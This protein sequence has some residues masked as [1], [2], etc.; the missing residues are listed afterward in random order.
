MC[1]FISR[2][3]GSISSAHMQCQSL[4]H[5]PAFGSTGEGAIAFPT[6]AT[7]QPCWWSN[8]CFYVLPLHA[9]PHPAMGFSPFGQ[10]WLPPACYFPFLHLAAATH[11][12]LPLSFKDLW[13]T[14]LLCPAFAVYP[15]LNWMRDYN[16]TP[17]GSTS[18]SSGCFK[19]SASNTT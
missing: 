7:R 8:L 15:R 9:S 1:Y 18:V 11:G 17:V 19:V 10:Q 6:Y 5:W 4:C 3:T 13:H 14:T 16:T 12:L 2:W